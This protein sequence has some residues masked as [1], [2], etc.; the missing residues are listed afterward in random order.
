MKQRRQ[1]GSLSNVVFRRQVQPA[2]N[3]PQVVP[4]PIPISTTRPTIASTQRPS[5]PLPLN[6]LA[7]DIN[8]LNIPIAVPI[9]ATSVEA[10]PYVE[11][12][13]DELRKLINHVSHAKQQRDYFINNKKGRGKTH[14][15]EEG[16]RL[17]QDFINDLMEINEN[18][19]QA[20]SQIRRLKRRK[21]ERRAFNV[22]IRVST[23]QT[24][25]AVYTHAMVVPHTPS[26]AAATVTQETRNAENTNI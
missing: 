21:R 15:A 2:Q 24:T 25:P 5:A 7:S 18:I 11:E 16:V 9:G 22:P 14:A 3:N 17:H 19:R 12:N 1:L 10:K 23:N 13:D 8:S 20:E 4:E 26:Q 6:S